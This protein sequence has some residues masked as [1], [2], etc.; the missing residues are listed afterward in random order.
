MRAMLFCLEQG[1]DPRAPARSA[2]MM[3][4]FS[5]RVVL[6]VGDGEPRRRRAV[7]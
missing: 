4:A 6:A 5:D 7:P 1:G 3:Q 2:L